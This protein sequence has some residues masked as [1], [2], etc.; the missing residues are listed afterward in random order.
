VQIGLNS[1]DRLAEPNEYSKSIH[2]CLERNW[3]EIAIVSPP[4]LVFVEISTS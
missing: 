1:V 4:D 2:L 3:I